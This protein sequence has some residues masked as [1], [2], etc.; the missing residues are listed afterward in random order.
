MCTEKHILMLGSLSCRFTW[1][2]RTTSHPRT[3][4]GDTASELRIL[5]RKLFNFEKDTGEYLVCRAHWRLSEG[6]VWW[7]RNL[8]C[9][10]SNQLSNIAVTCHYKHPAETCGGN[11]DLSAQMAVCLKLQFLPSHWTAE[12]K[13]HRNHRERLERDTRII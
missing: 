6:G 2:L 13:I 1:E 3:T 12:K 5:D 7:D 8:S 10:Q 9:H 11:S 4:G